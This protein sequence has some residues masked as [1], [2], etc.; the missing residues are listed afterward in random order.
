MVLHNPF[1]KVDGLMATVVVW[2]ITGG[3]SAAVE[4][5]IHCIC[6]NWRQTGWGCIRGSFRSEVV[7]GQLPSEHISI[8]ITT[9]ILLSLIACPLHLK[10]NWVTNSLQSSLA[11][12]TVHDCV[13][14]VL[15]VTVHLIVLL[16]DVDLLCMNGFSGN[17]YRLVWTAWGFTI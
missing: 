9:N 2:V 11:G 17:W 13:M 10:P 5:I 1:N 15:H 7:V 4:E 8:V 12:V 6:L 14:W 3:H 16:A